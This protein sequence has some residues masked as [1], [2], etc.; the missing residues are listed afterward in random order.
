MIH[1][2]FGSSVGVCFMTSLDKW[3]MT[4][5]YLT[6]KFYLRCEFRV[7]GE[8]LHFKLEYLQVEPVQRR[9]LLL[10]DLVGVS[11]ELLHL[12]LPGTQSDH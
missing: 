9:Q 4:A 7:V 5:V 2:S 1:V 10:C 8:C 12:G 11:K 6:D 3:K